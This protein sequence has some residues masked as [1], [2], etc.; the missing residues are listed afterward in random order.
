MKAPDLSLE[1]EGGKGIGGSEGPLTF[2]GKWEGLGSG[3][4]WEN[5]DEPGSSTG[6]KWLRNLGGV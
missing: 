1:R 4:V 6:F 3:Q 5:L 2:H